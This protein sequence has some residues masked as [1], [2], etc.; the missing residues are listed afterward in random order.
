MPTILIQPNVQ[1]FLLALPRVSMCRENLG[2]L[3]MQ[4][5]FLMGDLGRRHPA[6]ADEFAHRCEPFTPQDWEQIRLL[7]KPICAPYMT[8]CFDSKSV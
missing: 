3:L 6:C 8:H 2:H 5:V 4:A 1:C 7:S